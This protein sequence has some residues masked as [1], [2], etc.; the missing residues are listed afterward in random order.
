MISN[1]DLHEISKDILSNLQPSYLNDIQRDVALLINL[2]NRGWDTALWEM[3]TSTPSWRPPHQRGEFNGF[4]RR[5]RPNQCYHK[6]I[7]S[8]FST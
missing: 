6:T 8:G 3:A 4:G 5:E 1:K 7:I 2:N